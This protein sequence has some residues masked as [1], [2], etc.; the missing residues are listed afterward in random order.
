M[1][2]LTVL[3]LKLYFDESAVVTKT[4]TFKSQYLGFNKVSYLIQ[5]SIEAH[6]DYAKSAKKWLL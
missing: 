5:M 1:Y 2:L 6:N 4:F 3:V